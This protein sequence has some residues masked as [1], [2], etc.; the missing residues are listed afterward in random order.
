ML[1]LGPELETRSPSEAEAQPNRHS[2]KATGPGAEDFSR[3]ELSG[4][5]LAGTHPWG[6]CALDQVLP[7]PLLPIANRPLIDFAVG[8]L[9]RPGVAFVTV[10]GNSD[11][12]AI[13]SILSAEPPRGIRLDYY[14]DPMPRGPAGCVRDAAELHPSRTWVVVDGTIVPQIDLGDL[15]KAHYQSRCAMTVVVVPRSGTSARGEPDLVPMGIYVFSESAV[16]HIQRTGYQ[17]I[18]ETL[19]PALYSLGL[20]V[21]T[22]V[23]RWRAP[24]VTGAE[25]YMAVNDWAVRRLAHAT[26]NPPD[27][28]TRL[29]QALVHDSAVVHPSAPLIGAVLIGQDSRVDREATIVGPASIGAG[30]VVGRECIVC[31]SC[32][33][34]RC[35]L[36]AGCVV[37]RCI[38]THD[39]EIRAGLRIRNTVALSSR[40]AAARRRRSWANWPARATR[41]RV[42]QGRFLLGL[43]RRCPA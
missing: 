21:G 25:T 42:T 31:R 15:L 19:I 39:A 29:G 7:R 20:P 12:Q 38:L 2:E 43:R 8:W 5:V 40:A 33:W 41:N 32:L 1:I 10:C 17:D 27:G 18:K 13:R 11:T 30:C 22:F 34:D 37:D 9:D 35:T 24:R 6:W 36:D 28:Y 16:E 14:D 4:I 23:A 26:S 3:A